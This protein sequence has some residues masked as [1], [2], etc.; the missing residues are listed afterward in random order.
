[1]SQSSAE[2]DPVDRQQQAFDQRGKR[3][4]AGRVFSRRAVAVFG[5]TVGFAAGR[6]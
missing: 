6:V 5:A 3:V 4:L 1:M 2:I